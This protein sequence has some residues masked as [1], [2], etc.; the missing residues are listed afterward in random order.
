MLERGNLFVHDAAADGSRPIDD[1]GSGAR[2]GTAVPAARRVGW[3]PLRAVLEVREIGDAPLVFTVRRRWSLF[4]TR[5]VRDAEGRHVGILNGSVVQGP[6]DRRVVLGFDGAF[7]R[8]DGSIVARLR[9][10]KGGAALHFSSECDTDPFGKMLLL[11]AALL[12]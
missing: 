5:E 2:L 10:E 3:L 11:A 9:R 7:R 6:G 12:T 8:R 1:L 4:R